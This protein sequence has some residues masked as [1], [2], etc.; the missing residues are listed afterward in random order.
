MLCLELNIVS[1][2]R[3]RVTRFRDKAVAATRLARAGFQETVNE[4][5]H[6]GSVSDRC[7]YAVKHQL[8]C[9]W[10]FFGWLYIG[11]LTQVWH[12]RICVAEHLDE[13]SIP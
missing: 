11:R 10:R 9:H 13:H 3:F 4:R 8:A 5:S 1:L 6:D 2:C 12:Q 7:D